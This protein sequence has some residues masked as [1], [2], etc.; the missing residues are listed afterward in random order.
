MPRRL[1]IVDCCKESNRALE[2]LF[3]LSRVEVR[4]AEDLADARRAVSWRADA[5]LLERELPDGDGLLLLPS[6][7]RQ[8]PSPSIALYT[9]MAVPRLEVHPA[10]HYLR[11]PVTEKELMGWFASRV[12]LP[13]NDAGREGGMPYRPLN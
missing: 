6:L 12:A 5:V 3:R 1:L 13:P 2:F 7:L 11:K 8:M 4:V 9:A 10:V